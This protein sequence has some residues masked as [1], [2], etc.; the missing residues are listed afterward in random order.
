MAWHLC[1]GGGAA[2]RTGLLLPQT[3]Q[4]S[5]FDFRPGGA[6]I[7]VCIVLSDG[8]VENPPLPIQQRRILRIGIFLNHPYTSATTAPVPRSPRSFA[9]AENAR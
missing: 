2:G 8:C 4:D 1:P 6:C 9:S 5:L 7:R 3:V